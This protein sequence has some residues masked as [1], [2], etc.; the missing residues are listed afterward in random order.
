MFRE[1]FSCTV[2]GNNKCKERVVDPSKNLATFFMGLFIDKSEEKRTLAMSIL[3]PDYRCE[4]DIGFGG[5]YEMRVDDLNITMTETPGHC[6]GSICITI[7]DKYIFSGDCIIPGE[8]VVLNLPTGSRKEWNEKT[9]PYLNSLPDGMIVYPGHGEETTIALYK[10]E[11][12][13]RDALKQRK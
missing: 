12:L 9:V 8:N 13:E 5:V 4:V 11:Q 10:Q 2:Y 1:N 3:E 6:C 7:N